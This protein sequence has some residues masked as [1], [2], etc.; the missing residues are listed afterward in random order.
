[1]KFHIRKQCVLCLLDMFSRD[2]YKTDYDDL[3]DKRQKIIRDEILL[4]MEGI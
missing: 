3:C 2:I 1:M 4:L